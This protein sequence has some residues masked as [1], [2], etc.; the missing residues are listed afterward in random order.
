M[1]P[2][3]QRPAG[4]V[5]K[6]VMG[7]EPSGSHEFELQATDLVPVPTDVAAMAK[8][9]DALGTFRQTSRRLASEQTPDHVDTVS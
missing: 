7:F 8:L 9:L 4:D 2:G 3:A 6:A 1:H 5:E